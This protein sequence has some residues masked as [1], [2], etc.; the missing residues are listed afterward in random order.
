MG[1]LQASMA[2]LIW[3]VVAAALFLVELSVPG[4]GG[5]IIA[6]VAAL[7]VSVLT[8][9]FGLSL[10]LQ[11]VLFGLLS[12]AGGAGL[13]RW[14]ARQRPKLERIAPQS[15]RAEVI[16]AFDERGRGRVRW[17]G[18]SWAA[19]SLEDPLR[20]Q[21]GDPVVVMRRVGTRLEVLSAER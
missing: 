16:A 14:Q 11:V 15:D 17:Q 6:A 13:W 7:M 18:Q 8:A 1:P 19:E 21:P 20:L 4:F 3:L 2:P 10:P 12:V 9:L 5:F